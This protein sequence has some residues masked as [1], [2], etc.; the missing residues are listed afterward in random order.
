MGCPTVGVGAHTEAA[1]L[2]VDL[3]GDYSAGGNGELREHHRLLRRAVLRCEET[4]GTTAKISSARAGNDVG[5]N[6]VRSMKKTAPSVDL[7]SASNVHALKSMP[8][9]LRAPGSRA[10]P[11]IPIVRKESNSVS[12]LMA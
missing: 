4:P 9:L 5:V 8:M 2:R 1:A 6:D 10:G 11:S 3:A 12:G 7:M